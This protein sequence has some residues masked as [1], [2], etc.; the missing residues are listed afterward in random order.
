LFIKK[1]KNNSA[2]KFFRSPL[3][4]AAK[5]NGKRKKILTSSWPDAEAS[6]REKLTKT[7]FFY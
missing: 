5:K 1:E 6:R 2:K 4:E 3:L 7:I